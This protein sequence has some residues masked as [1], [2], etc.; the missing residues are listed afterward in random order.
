MFQGSPSNICVPDKDN[1]KHTG[2]GKWEVSSSPGNSG[3]PNFI[4]G[5]I[6]GV[7]SG[8]GADHP[9]GQLIDGTDSIF[10]HEYL[11]LNY[12]VE[13][14]SNLNELSEMEITDISNK[15]INRVY[16]LPLE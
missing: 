14:I 16:S 5:R 1:V 3:G 13:Y 8:G 4:D 15:Y 2:L 7:G 9:S 12:G 10:L 6:A 11:D